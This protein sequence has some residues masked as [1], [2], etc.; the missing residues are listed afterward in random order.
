MTPA[1]RR[2]K[3]ATW[4]EFYVVWTIIVAVCLGFWL[5]LAWLGWSLLR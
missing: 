2:A 5:M 4:V 1:S 3:R